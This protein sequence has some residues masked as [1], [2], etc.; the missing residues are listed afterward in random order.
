MGRKAEAEKALKAVGL[1]EGKL[2]S[3]P[4]EGLSAL[5]E[6]AKKA[7]VK[8]PEPV[9]KAV[10]ARLSIFDQFEEQKKQAEQHRQQQSGVR[11]FSIQ[12]LL[13][14]QKE[15]LQKDEQ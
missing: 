4:L 13:D 7:E 9:P 1:P 8:A 2:L 15:P 3:K 5:K 10:G 11:Q 6:Q 12:E 14:A